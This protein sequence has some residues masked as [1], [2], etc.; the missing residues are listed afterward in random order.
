MCSSKEKKLKI[1]SPRPLGG[2]GGPQPALSSAGAGRVRGFLPFANPLALLLLG[3]GLLLSPAA[4]M[5][6]SGQSANSPALS[7]QAAQSSPPPGQVRPPTPT[8]TTYTL[9]PQR[10]A[11]AIAY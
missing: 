4:R 1:Y 7:P 10:R 6:G 9:T 5:R 2:E 3:I 8:P 11:Q